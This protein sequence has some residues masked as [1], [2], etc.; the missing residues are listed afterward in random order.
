MMGKGIATSQQSFPVSSEQLIPEISLEDQGI[1]AEDA[2][3]INCK[4]NALYVSSG[5][6]N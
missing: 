2:I 1:I 5:S 3:T 6:P 4:G